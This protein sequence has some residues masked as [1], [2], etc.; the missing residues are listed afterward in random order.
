[1]HPKDAAFPFDHVVD[2]SARPLRVLD[3]G[4]KKYRSRLSLERVERQFGERIGTFLQKE[5]HPGNML[6]LYL[7]PLAGSDQS[8][9][10]AAKRMTG[11][12]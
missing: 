3:N 9:V 1:V 7:Y 11:G 8:L 4:V 2:P 12:T 6:Y 10:D 5:G